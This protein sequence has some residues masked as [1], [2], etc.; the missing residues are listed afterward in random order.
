M[1]YEHLLMYFFAFVLG[2]M[3][4]KML[5]GNLVEGAEGAT[6]VIGCNPTS[7]PAQLCPG[8]IAC[9]S[10]G[11]CPTPPQ[12]GVPPP[13]QQPPS[14]GQAGSA[15]DSTANNPKSTC[16][17]CKEYPASNSHR[18]HGVFDYDELERVFPP[19][20]AKFNLNVCN[21]DESICGDNPKACPCSKQGDDTLSGSPW[22]QGNGYWVGVPWENDPNFYLGRQE[23]YEGK[24]VRLLQSCDPSD[25]QY[26]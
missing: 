4:S 16:T 9:P 23:V 11:I 5:R 12:G 2:F 6:T 13:S 17:L 25:P 21:G 15:C 19:A 20:H 24:Y 1:K 10:T 3:V 7:K 26:Q 22:K 8:N 18:E 14:N